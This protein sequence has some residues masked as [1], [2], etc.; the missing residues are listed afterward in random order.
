[1]AI[2]LFLEHANASRVENTLIMT[3]MEYMQL[4]IGSS[5]PVFDTNFSKCFF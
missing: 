1:M 5:L 4:Q 3:S 2:K